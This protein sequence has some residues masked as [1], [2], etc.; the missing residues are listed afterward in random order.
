MRNR[1]WKGSAHKQGRNCYE[2]LAAIEERE[3]DLAC[4]IKGG[5]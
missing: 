2:I 4:G 5:H 1:L 3:R